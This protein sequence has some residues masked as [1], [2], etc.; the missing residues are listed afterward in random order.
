MMAHRKKNKLTE[1]GPFEWY[2]GIL[3]FR[4]EEYGSNR[5][6]NPRSMYNV[7]ENMYLVKANTAEKAYKKCLSEGKGMESIECTDQDTGQKGRWVFVGINELLPVYE[8]LED[9]AEI[10]W[11]THYK[12]LASIERMVREKEELGAFRS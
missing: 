1:A 4:Y 3:I 7:H 12:S 2:I 8:K 10:L 6:R 11:T 5:S 9:G